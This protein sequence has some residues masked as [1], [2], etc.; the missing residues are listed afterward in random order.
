MTGYSKKYA[1]DKTPR[2]LQGE[3]TSLETK[4]RIKT[5]IIQINM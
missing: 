2:F 4:L 3:H 1:L 5:K